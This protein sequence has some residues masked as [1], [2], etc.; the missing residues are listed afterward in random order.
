MVQGCFNM[1]GKHIRG[2]FVLFAVSLFSS[3]GMYEKEIITS[4][5]FPALQLFE[6]SSS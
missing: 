1:S 4:W 3:I 6:A 5:L 2:K